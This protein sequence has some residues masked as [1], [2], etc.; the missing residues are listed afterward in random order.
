[1]LKNLLTA[2]EL[3]HLEN[4]ARDLVN[5]INRFDNWYDS[6]D[7]INSWRSGKQYEN[8]LLE[9]ID[10]TLLFTAEEKVY[11][12]KGMLKDAEAIAE[13]KHHFAEEIDWFAC[14][15]SMAPAVKFIMSLLR[16]LDDSKARTDAF[17]VL[18][19]EKERIALSKINYAIDLAN[20]LSENYPTMRD[21]NVPQKNWFIY[22]PAFA[23]RVTDFTCKLKVSPAAQEC[24]DYI[25][26]TF[27]EDDFS[28]L[29]RMG[30]KVRTMLTEHFTATEPRDVNPVVG[31]RNWCF[32]VFRH[33]RTRHW[34]QDVTREDI[35]QAIT[36]L[37]EV[38]K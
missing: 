36:K 38:L 35:D 27:S 29:E 25:S 26:Q 23:G 5:G 17:S 31:V 34:V 24:Y 37:N 2:V 20:Y 4:P 18:K 32:T 12:R 3:S 8:A 7:C 30:G 1:M 15:Y 22:T 21:V 19:V 16:E 13:F 6:T 10:T 28:T 11:L 33:I 14:E 9:E